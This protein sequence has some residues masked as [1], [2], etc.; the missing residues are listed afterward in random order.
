[1]GIANPPPTK[2]DLTSQAEDKRNSLLKAADDIMLDWRTEL[3]L[4]VIGDS[5]MYKL[6]L[7]LSYKNDVKAADVSSYPSGKTFPPHARSMI[8]HSAN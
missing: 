7:L 1:M 8:M 2:E 4:G 3:M 5:N 6:S